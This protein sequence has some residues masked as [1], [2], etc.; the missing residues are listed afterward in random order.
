MTTIRR[1]FRRFRA[2]SGA[3][4]PEYAL[5]LG[6]FAVL[7]F[8][9]INQLRDESDQEMT[10]TSECIGKLPSEPGCG[11]GV[12][13]VPPDPGDPTSDPDG[14]TIPNSDDNCPTTFN[15]DQ[16]DNDG[17]GQGNECDPTPNGDDDGDNVDNLDDNCRFV[18]NPPDPD[19]G[20]QLDT[21]DDG[22]GDACDNCPTT[23]NSTQTDTDSD[24]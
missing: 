5:L 22:P 18:P 11:L 3:T 13:E 8:G 24:S 16:A 7:S 15:S 20:E 6:A 14:D 1:C 17:D 2:Q 4:V 12:E 9:A 23:S 19:T 21:D 10:E